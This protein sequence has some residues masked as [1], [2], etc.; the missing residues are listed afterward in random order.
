MRLKYKNLRTTK[1]YR[2]LENIQE[3]IRPIITHIKNNIQMEN[4]INEKDFNK[5]KTNIKTDLKSCKKL[6][7]SSRS[8]RRK[9]LNNIIS[10]NNINP[11]HQKLLAPFVPLQ[12]IKSI[13]ENYN[14]YDMV[15]FKYKSNTINM[16]AFYKTK[17]NYKELIIK[18]VKLFGLMEYQKYFNKKINIYYAPTNFTK[19]IKYKKFIGPDSVNSAFC[20]FYP[21]NYIAVF[22]KECSDKVILHELIHYLYIEPSSLVDNIEDMNNFI[23]NDMNVNNDSENISFFE[24]YTDSIA[25]IFNTVIDSI[26]FEKN[27]NYYFYTELKYL[28]DSVLNLLKHF[29]F[30]NINELFDKKS[31]KKFIQKSNVVAYYIL[32]LGL[33][34]EVDKLLTNFGVSCGGKKC[35]VKNLKWTS[36]K[37]KD[38]YFFSKKNLLNKNFKHNGLNKTK[39]LKMCYNLIIY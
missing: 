1:K 23:I 19:R 11:M 13:V 18:C 14:K 26:L 29:G 36:K 30:K 24:S 6:D 33:L 20:Q 7:S 17:I 9:I 21:D 25:I 22:R 12:I 4:K 37:Y 34:C 16:H 38:L 31:D 15:I 28:S 10:T 3:K 35:N 5:I 32:K 39:S 8:T 2:S 27:I